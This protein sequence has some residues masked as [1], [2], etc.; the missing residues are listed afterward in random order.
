MAIAIPSVQTLKLP[1]NVKKPAE[2]ML[3]M[4]SPKQQAFPG[5][6]Y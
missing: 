2:F 6:D 1:K 3:L 5:R 4:R